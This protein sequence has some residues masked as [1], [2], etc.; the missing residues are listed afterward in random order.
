MSHPARY[1]SLVAVR[2][3]GVELEVHVTQ[4]VPQSP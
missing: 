4:I 3:A 2:C 1:L